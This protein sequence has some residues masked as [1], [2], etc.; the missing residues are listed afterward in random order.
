MKSH[1]RLVALLIFATLPC[2]A[3]TLT[4]YDN[5]DHKFINPSRWVYAFCSP[6]DGPE[7]ECVREIRDEQLHLAHRAFGLTN[8]N[9]G[10]NNGAAGVGFAN[11][12]TIKTIKTDLVVRSVLEVPCAANGSFGSSAGIWGTFFNTGS[13][14]PN[15][16]AG[17]Q[18]GV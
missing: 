10:Q 14:N 5:F 11:S 18:L 12:E 17:A 15:D 13:G 8:S 4:P 7:L 2:A 6:G 3:Q 1:Y 16:D 9:T